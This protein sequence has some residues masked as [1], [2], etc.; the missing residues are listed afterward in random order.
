MPSAL[1]QTTSSARPRLRPRP[2]TA[3]QPVIGLPASLVLH[4]LAIASIFFVFNSS[5]SPPQES[6][7]V[8]VELVTL[9]RETNVA[10]AAPPPPPDLEPVQRDL[11]PLEPPPMPEI[12]A[13]PA[14]DVPP[15]KIE[16]QKEKPPDTR[17]DITSL[18]NQLTR[19]QKPAPNN[20]A[21]AATESA[22]LSN[23]MTA[24]LAD[25]LRS[26]IRNCWSPIAGAPNPADQIVSFDL[27]LNPDGTIA[28]IETLTVSSNPYTAAAVSAAERAIYQCSPYRL[29]ASS[30][31]QWRQFRPLRFDPRQMVQQ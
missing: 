14:P 26:Q 3:R 1:S 4:G 2:T 7:A 5:F 28:S 12:R 11:S 29:P 16:I 19:P 15:P 22:G 6:H 10:A 20:R 24:S 25:M 30:Y 23:A 8:P 13:E 31:S 9:A 27:R 18:L 17:Q 21:Q